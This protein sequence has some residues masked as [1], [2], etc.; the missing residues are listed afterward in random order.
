M[1][2]R[3]YMDSEF[4]DYK[5]IGE[6]VR[7]NCPFCSPN[8]DY[9]L[10]VKVASDSTDGLWHCKKCDSSGNPV[11][12][13]MRYDQV[14]F[15]E[16]LDILELYGYDQENLEFEAKRQGLTVEEL[17]V[18]MIAN[19]DTPIEEKEVQELVPPA[20][21]I[22]YRRIV[23]NL[24]DPAVV[25]FIN[26]LIYK[27]HYTPE[28]IFKHN[29][30][31]ITNGYA[32]SSQGKKVYLNN[33]VVFLTHGDKGEY[34]YWNTRSIEP[35]PGIK[36]FNGIATDGEY[37][38]RTTVF[39]LNSACKEPS[40]V[41]VEGVTDALTVGVSGVG[42]FGKQVT[43]EQV[44]L[45]LSHVNKEQKIYVMLDR[46]ADEQAVNL[47]SKLYS[48]HENTYIVINETY[49]DPNDLGYDKTWEV[50]RNSSYLA[51]NARL[52]LLFL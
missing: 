38:K 43:K 50:I 26:Y 17:L 22:G 36:S 4:N 1:S 13:I 18:M 15:K 14:D 39:N 35:N 42:T 47:A 20:L 29:V 24:E 8:T 41:I 37:S 48:K 25:P 12:F 6:E 11:T 10:Y 34:Q 40:I 9:K 7:Y 5:D 28:D 30:G 45:I 31:Y 16:A 32:L 19:M 49:Q 33:H 23:D 27:R 46:D 51:D 44:A 3:D 2:F 21:P 52:S